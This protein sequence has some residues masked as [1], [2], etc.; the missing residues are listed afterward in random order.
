[1]GWNPKRS[2]HLTFVTLKILRAFVLQPTVCYRACDLR[3]A[4]NLPPKGVLYPALVRLIAYK[5]IEVGADRRFMITSLGLQ[6]A[7]AALEALQIT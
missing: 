5:W 1:M 3:R 2:P 6:E 4:A 7:R